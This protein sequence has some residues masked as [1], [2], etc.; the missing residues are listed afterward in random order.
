MN[1][2]PYDQIL[3]ARRKA[4]AVDPL[5]YYRNTAQQVET[6]PEDADSA[7]IFERIWHT[8]EGT[9]KSL[10]RGAIDSVE[11][12]VDLGIGLVGGVGGMFSP[13]FRQLM[14]EAVEYDAVQEWI[15][16]PMDAVVEDIRGSR[17][18]EYSYIEEGSLPDMVIE[19]VG[20][21]LPAVAI[22]IATAGLGA[23]A[24]A[25]GTAGTVAKVGGIAGKVGLSAAKAAKVAQVA[26]MATMAAGAAGQA[27]EEAYRDGA[28]YYGGL[29]YG[30]ARGAVEA[31]TEYA[32]GGFTK[33]LTGGGKLLPGVRQSVAPTGVKRVIKNAVE[34][35]LE[36]M[37]SEASDPATRTIYQGPEA[38]KK[39]L[40]PETYKQIGQAG[41]VGTATG[42]VFQGTIGHALG[43]SGRAADMQEI[44]QELD[45]LKEKKRNLGKNNKLT[46]EAYATI[47]EAE[48]ENY[49][50][51]ETVLQKAT[52]EKRA[53][54]MENYRLSDK[55]TED[56]TM[57]A[58][59]VASLDRK[60]TVG[61]MAANAENGAPAGSVTGRAVLDRRT[62]SVD[63][64]A[65]QV[66]KVLA[67]EG[68]TQ[69]TDVDSLSKEGQKNL[70]NV[71]RVMDVF[72][73]ISDGA[74]G[75][76]V[77][78]NESVGDNA[79]YDPETGYIVI[80]ADA[81]EKG[82]DTT[83]KGVQ[84][85]FQ[86]VLHEATHG[87][88]G[89]TP[90]HALGK[91]LES[92]TV[93]TEAG[94]LNLGSLAIEEII[95]RGY[96][97]D[98]AETARTRIEDLLSMEGDLRAFFENSGVDNKGEVQYNKKKRKSVYVQIS[99]RE[100]AVL[101]AEVTRKRAAYQ[102]R[103]ESVPRYGCGYTDG[104]FYV[105]ENLSDYNF[106]V[107]KQ[108]EIRPETQKFIKKVEGWIEEN[109]RADQ[110]AKAVDRIIASIRSG[111]G[112]DRGR[113]S[114]GE[115][116]RADSGAE[117][118]SGSEQESNAGRDYGGG[119]SNQRGD[120]KVKTS[121]KSSY[122]SDDTVMAQMEKDLADLEKLNSERTAI[123]VER[124]LGNEHFA[125]Q[126][127]DLDASI[128]E[129]LLNRIADVK[130]ALSRL[131]DPAAKEAFAEIKKAEQ[132]FLDALAEKGM[133]FE[134]GKIIGAS[135]EDEVKKS[136]TSSEKTA[137]TIDK[138]YER[139]IDRWR[140]LKEGSYITVGDIKEHSALSKVGMPQGRL[141]FDVSKIRKEMEKH[142]DHLSPD[143]MKKIPELLNEPIVI[144]EY[145]PGKNTN[146]VNVFGR[147]FAQNSNNTP[148]FV[149]I[150]AT[151]GRGGTVVTKIR[152]VHTRSDW[153]DM[154]TDDSVLYLNENKKE[155]DK[156]F[157]ARGNSVPLGG[158]KYGLIRS[159]SL[160]EQKV[161]PSDEIS[162]ENSSKP[163]QKSRKANSQTSG[164]TATW[165]KSPP[166][167][168]YLGVDAT[169]R[170]AIVDDRAYGT[171]NITKAIDNVIAALQTEIDESVEVPE[172]KELVVK[173]SEWKK[174][175][176]VNEL[177]NKLK[178]AKTPQEQDAALDAVID[179]V[180]AD[181]YVK[182]IISNESLMRAVETVNR[183][184]QYR[185]KID[186][187]QTGVSK[188]IYQKWGK[189]DG[190]PL[191]EVMEDL[192]TAVRLTNPE[193]MIAVMQ[194]V[195]KAYEEAR[196]YIQINKSHKIQY[197]MGEAD[198]AL[199]RERMKDAFKADLT[200]K[201]SAEA[202]E[203]LEEQYHKQHDRATNVYNFSHRMNT[204]FKLSLDMRDIK[205]GRFLNQ[206]QPENHNILNR[207]LGQLCRVMNG[208]S[209]NKSCRK[210][211]REAYE[212][213]VN[214]AKKYLKF[215]P[216][217]NQGEYSPEI[218]EKL[219][220]IGFSESDSFTVEELGDIINI[221]QYFKHMAENYQ[222]VWRNGKLVEAQPYATELVKI[223]KD[224]LKLNSGK[225]NHI[226]GSAYMRMYGDPHMLVKYMDKYKLGFYTTMF[227]RIREGTVQSQIIMKRM[228]DK[229]NEALEDPKRKEKREEKNRQRG[230]DA[231]EPAA[232][233]TKYFE[234]LSKR[235]IHLH[236]ADMP[237]GEAISLYMTCNR[238]QAKAGLLENGYSFA[239][240]DDGKN[241]HIRRV[242]GFTGGEKVRDKQGRIKP[243]YQ[244]KITD[245][246]NE[247]YA[248]LSEL[249]K[250]FIAVA[251]DI[252]QNDCKDLK[253]ATDLALNGWSNAAE[254]YYFPIRRYETFKSIDKEGFFGEVDRVTNASFNKNTQPGA[255]NQLL[256]ESIDVVLN[257]HMKGVAKYAALGQVI[258]D[259][260]TLRTLDVSGNPN[261]A[262]S[263]ATVETEEGGWHQGTEYFYKLLSDVQGI[264]SGDT[265][266]V[267][268]VIGKVRGNYA[269]FALAANP[270]VVMTQLS[271]VFAGM[272]IIDADCML[273][274]FSD[275][276]RDVFTYSELAELRA[277][278]NTAAMAQ[279]LIDEA[280]DVLMKP[281][282][283]MDSYVVR[284]LWVAAQHQVAKDQKLKV[285]TEENKKAAGKLL[286]TVIFETQQNS[287]ATEKSQAARSSSEFQ[288]MV[289]MFTSDAVK[290][291]GQLLDAF[292]EVSVIRREAK[293][294]GTAVDSVRLKAAEKRLG[295]AAASLAAVAIYTTILS[296]LFR[297]LLKKEDEEEPWS[298]FMADTMG[299]MLGGLPLISD[300]YE[301][302]FGSG[303]GLEDMSIA[304]VND[305]M[306]GI[307][308][309]FG[310]AGAFVTGDL[311]ERDLHKDLRKMFFA[312]GQ[313][314]GLPTRNLYNYARAAVHWVSPETGYKMDNAFAKQAYTSHIAK[315]I[316]AE[317]EGRLETVIG[318]MLDENVGEVTSQT[319]R[320]EMN[321][322][323]YAGMD[324]LP[325]GVGDTVTVD[326][327]AVK[328]TA[329]QKQAFKSV[330]SE[331]NKSV[332]KMVGLS[333][334]A[335][336]SDEAKAKAIK[337]VYGIYY[338]RAIE[339][340]LGVELE[341][342]NTLLAEAID[343]EVLAVV[344]A[345]CGE[346]EADKDANG[347]AI[348]G[349]KRRKVEDFVESLRL[350]AA[351]KYIIM[352]ALGYKNKLGEAKVQAYVN[353]L[354]L[355]KDEREALMGCSGY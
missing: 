321:R 292:G 198:E 124:F 118:I 247:I 284:R 112:H 258:R 116:R 228:N 87:T 147:L 74:V 184:K 28:G 9:V 166:T 177:I 317:D 204:I 135:E 191:A 2:N 25:A 320:Q 29:G 129:K 99:K 218:A 189:K 296:Q 53:A 220:R 194:D 277:S 236:G 115:H 47:S 294:N 309:L 285:G 67:K 179:T 326:G 287:L 208:G 311:D 108:I 248:Q 279:G 243:E 55:F 324:V 21:M 56:G 346:I 128:V 205:A 281:I 264:K 144:T 161:N 136:K 314:T 44:T 33:G 19:G 318:V 94:K 159:I 278:E 245:M 308:S 40:D 313:V 188:P 190:I 310:T 268:K 224:N 307:K 16:D 251:Q 291:M 222:K 213:Y 231:R 140:E 157:Q 31:G 336:A 351:Q 39:Y 299:A 183:L 266:E 239:G 81:L 238:E 78:A 206:S 283:W 181:A 101:S 141:Y 240:E 203:R 176:S 211:F 63:A 18:G 69:F 209:L 254:E 341:N 107:L 339:D 276:G 46:D 117:R 275:R 344:L 149:G 162:S 138:Y 75:E 148:I 131:R 306:E 323:V 210:Y 125:R 89:A 11:G 255:K 43:N 312:L 105:Y 195:D 151:K 132:M 119:S 80:G 212:W 155:T 127:L 265:D 350:K 84:S 3:A 197:F 263:I 235:M 48:R 134:G 171:T 250:K 221:C 113:A 100:Y 199:L 232:R 90:S 261:A 187:T 122:P 217:T 38:L 30:I 170:V 35:G 297:K 234:S 173:L 163:V 111:K 335:D 146:T 274:G 233:N 329:R 342:K 333:C 86:T 241:E 4:S 256:I 145:N 96:F 304:A 52:P 354:G 230:G 123:M 244:Q 227:E 120:T 60:A 32:L 93:D 319:V 347:K 15:Y 6:T 8:G 334:Y 88:E 54:L 286:E 249:D 98:D 106:G 103:G 7:G 340:L 62:A 327:E 301:Y 315:A 109:G 226:I 253:R 193:D 202:V 237:V 73:D 178:E 64:D 5:D 295:R 77:I 66:A 12:I 302:F 126:L 196:Q 355:S 272:N 59:F 352:G 27:T 49:R 61:Q 57:K 269:R 164:K 154:I 180:M 58:D 130:D 288:K 152:T 290:G 293:I 280:G 97:G 150:V 214:D 300:A 353:G 13:K 267:T 72:H 158:T 156:W 26:S 104:F 22:S 37:I 200:A 201:A 20:G 169:E 114:D 215:D 325:R 242:F 121:R 34:E 167:K 252:L 260:D 42:G 65:E 343:P 174:S 262:V 303:Y 153:S 216:K 330:Y 182:T 185:R 142:S 92:L 23:P 17:I 165:E 331:A 186:L 76:F 257:R 70:R 160:V 322:L 305:L 41:I 270:K 137:F 45:T 110:D 36:E 91:L 71:K 192:P 10:T 316:E 50:V 143:I 79:Y 1:I 85:W 51:M 332:E 259:Y 282:G 24:A 219:Q 175:S 14:K 95:E 133:R 225:M 349:S 168:K 102:S 139:Q 246:Q 172:N 223:S 345:I 273:K 83:R 68:R 348:S 338:N 328:L 298:G 207:T 289:T 229:I 337:R 82:I 271:S